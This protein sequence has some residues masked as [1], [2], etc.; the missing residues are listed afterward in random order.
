MAGVAVLLDAVAGPFLVF[1]F[2]GMVIQKNVDT[3]LARRSG[4]LLVV[5]ATDNWLCGCQKKS[6][7]FMWRWFVTV[8]VVWWLLV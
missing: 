8:V 6:I 1:F 2:G 4:V 5:A 3:E 7:G